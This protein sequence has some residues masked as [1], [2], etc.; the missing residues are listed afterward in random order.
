LEESGNGRS[1]VNRI[2][3]L[4]FGAMRPDILSDLCEGLAAEFT[5]PCEVLQ[6]EADPA[7]AFNVTRQQYSSTEILAA[8]SARATPDTWR[9]LGVT[10]HDLYIP[11]LTFV[12]G[13]AQLEGRCA[14]VSTKRL[15]EGFYGLPEDAPLFRKRLLK[16]SVHELGHTLTLSHC[17]DYQCVM[18]PSHGVEWIDL[19]T[20]RFCGECRTR[21]PSRAKISAGKR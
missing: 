5:V 4:P 2:Q 16:E 10:A 11:I 14:V 12:F 15:G 7:F 18:A 20:H 8:M 9:L 17:E 13:E 6:A 19:K 1:V 3:L 21:V